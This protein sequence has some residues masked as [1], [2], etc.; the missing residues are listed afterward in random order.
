MKIPRIFHQIWVGL[1]PFPDEYVALQ[2]TW[3]R[4]NPDWELRFWRDDNLPEG[5]R[6]P[7]VYDALAN[8]M[9]TRRHPPA[10]GRAAVRG[11]P[12]RRRLRVAT[13]R[14]SRSWTTRS[15]SSSATAKPGHVNGALF[16]AV[17]GHPLLEEG[18]ATIQPRAD[19]A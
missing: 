14:S 8:A 7:E 11:R 9:G 10:R 13:A 5:L 4:H 3:R 12:R 15:S 19:G 16:G 18:L 17:A 2:E 1:E 6:R